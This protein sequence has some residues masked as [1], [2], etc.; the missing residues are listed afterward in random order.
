MRCERR[1]TFGSYGTGPR[2]ALALSSA[3]IPPNERGGFLRGRPIG[4]RNREGGLLKRQANSASYSTHFPNSR[5]EKHKCLPVHKFS[6]MVVKSET[7]K[8]S[9]PFDH[10]STQLRKQRKGLTYITLLSI[11]RGFSRTLWCSL[12]VGG[13]SG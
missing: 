13:W 10:P 1:D 12:L 2:P 6:P 9:V 8:F 7:T 11:L 4:S 3:A 5:F